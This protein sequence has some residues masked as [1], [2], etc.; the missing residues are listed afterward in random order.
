MCPG[1]ESWERKNEGQGLA[2]HRFRAGGEAD[3]GLRAQMG[4]KG[5]S[6]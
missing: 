3:L 6:L 4:R 5:S 2:G 1:E